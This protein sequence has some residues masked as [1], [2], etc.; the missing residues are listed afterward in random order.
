M[1]QNVSFLRIRRRSMISSAVEDMA[2]P[3]YEIHDA[4]SGRGI[5]GGFVDFNAF[6]ASG[7]RSP[8]PLRGVLRMHGGFYGVSPY[9][10]RIAAPCGAV[11]IVFDPRPRFPATAG[12]RLKFRGMTINA[13]Q[14]TGGAVAG[15]IRSEEDF[16]RA[17]KH[18]RRVGALKIGLPVGALLVVAAFTGWSWLA[19]PEGFTADMTGSAIRGG[20]LVMA[21]PKL[22]GFTN[23]N[24]PYEVTAERAVQNLT[25]TSIITLENIDARLPIE[26]ESWADIRAKTGIFDNDGNTLDVTGPMTIRTNGGLTVDLKSAFVDMKSG[27]IVSSEPV[28]VSMNGSTLEADA[29]TVEERGKVVV[30]EDR[31]RMTVLPRRVKSG[32]EDG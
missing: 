19:A 25:D 3:V 14:Q 24:L 2:D 16:L 22:N 20:N 21:N 1:R 12:G 23:D 5:P 31:V 9:N 18:S 28:G 4:G 13:D 15:S 27:R 26:A 32:D 11:H 29:M 6:S 30:F 8:A 17:R 10:N 7:A